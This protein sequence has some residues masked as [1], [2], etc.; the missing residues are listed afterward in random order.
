MPLCCVECKPCKGHCLPGLFKSRRPAQQLRR[1]FGKMKVGVGG[2]RRRRRAGSFSSVRAVFWPLMSMRS[3]ADARND[4][5]AESRPP[6]SASTD[7]SVVSVGARAPSPS[8]DNDTPGATAST[9][10][11]RVLAL[12]ARLDAAPPKLA[13]TPAAAKVSSIGVAAR[14]E[15]RAIVRH[16]EEAADVEAACRSFERHLV[17]MLVEERKV[18]DLTDVE[19]LLCCWEK[20]RCP[21]F[22]KLVGRFYGELCMDLFTARDANVSSEAAEAL[23]LTACAVD[24]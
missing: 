11:A 10:A 13:L 19:E 23:T 18:M 21:A 2:T 24:P 12:Q 15:A 16:G 14:E 17:E 6:A 5:A 8:L 9:T 22:V 1:A 4:A 3:E 7:G 20:L